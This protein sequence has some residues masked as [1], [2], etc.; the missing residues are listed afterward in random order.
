MPS[1]YWY[2][3]LLSNEVPSSNLNSSHSNWYFEKPYF[4]HYWSHISQMLRQ[5]LSFLSTYQ[6]RPKHLADRQMLL[7]NASKG[8]RM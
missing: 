1:P 7:F 6:V 4:H 5:N 2:L 3:A 8:H